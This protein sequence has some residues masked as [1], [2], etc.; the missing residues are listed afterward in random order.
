LSPEEKRVLTELL[1][2]GV[3]F[4]VVGGFAVRA[5]GYLR[6]V[7]DLD[8]LVETTEQ[9]LR[10]LREAL[11]TVGAD[12]P[13]LIVEHLSKPKA[14]V[15]WRDVEFFSSMC[16]LPFHAVYKAAVYQQFSSGQVLVMS[17]P[18]LIEAKRYAQQA[19]D[20]GPKANQDRE[21]LLWLIDQR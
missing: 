8:L 9:N 6:P 19:D 5:H 2:R 11:F 16:G 20:R 18:H 21:D 7:E 1:K 10:E 4:V 13:D 12:K 15:I 14:K 3:R 17:R